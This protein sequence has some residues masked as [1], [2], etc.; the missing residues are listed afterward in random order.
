MVVDYSAISRKIKSL[1]IEKNMY[2]QDI[3][4]ELGVSVQTYQEW[5]NN[6]NNLK[7]CNIIALSNILKVNLLDIFLLYA[8]TKCIN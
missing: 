2:Q 7:F 4:E 8:D 1:R 5:E 6:P 3:A